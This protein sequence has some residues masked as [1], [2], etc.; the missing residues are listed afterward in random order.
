MDVVGDYSVEEGGA[1]LVGLT[2][3]VKGR[4]FSFGARDVLTKWEI[5]RAEN[6]EVH[7]NDA[8]VS[9]NHAQLVND[10]GRWKLIDLMSANGTYVN[11]NKCLT[12]YLESGDSVR[13]GKQEF[14]FKASGDQFDYDD[15]EGGSGRRTDL[16]VVAAF[17]VIVGAVLIGFF[18]N[19]F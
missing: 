7:I 2:G 8:S 14:M 16:W 4:N 9:R 13:F 6:S 1:V 11:G 3:P 17:A 12:S 18:S 15:D 5:G 19:S 10:K